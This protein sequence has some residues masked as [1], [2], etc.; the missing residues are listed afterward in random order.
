MSLFSTIDEG[1]AI[2]D[3]AKPLIEWV[4][5]HLTRFL[6]AIHASS[7]AFDAW[8]ALVE[9]DAQKRQAIDP[10]SPTAQDETAKLNQESYDHML[11]P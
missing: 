6:A 9:G 11:T 2:Y 4:S 1:V 10:A 5:T 3:A 7:A 8:K